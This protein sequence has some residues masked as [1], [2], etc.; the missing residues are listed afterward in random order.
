MLDGKWVDEI[1]SASYDVVGVPLTLEYLL[2]P[3]S[4]PTLLFSNL[5]LGNTI[6]LHSFVKM[7][8][9][10]YTQDLAYASLELH[11]TLPNQRAMKVWL[12]P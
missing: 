5:S 6:I 7:A 8:D 3:S 12:I 1:T 4:L 2:V 10:F 9:G 11:P